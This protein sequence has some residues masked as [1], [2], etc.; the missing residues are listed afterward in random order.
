MTNVRRR[1]KV[2]QKCTRNNLNN[3]WYKYKSSKILTMTDWSGLGL[4][5]ARL[6]PAT[7]IPPSLIGL[8]SAN[9]RLK[10]PSLLLSSIRYHLISFRSLSI[11]S[12]ES[13]HE[14]W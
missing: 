10:F 14:N 2:P 9:I 5:I 1:K 3:H 7:V 12:W 6:G 11:S 13:C 4:A 8:E